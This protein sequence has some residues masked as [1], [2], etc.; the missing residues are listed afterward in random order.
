MKSAVHLFAFI[1]IFALSIQASIIEVPTDYP[2]IQQ[3][4]NASVSGDLVL[5]APGTYVENIDFNGKNILLKSTDGPA[6]TTIDGS[7]PSHPDLASVVS[8]KNGEG[9]DAVLEGFTITGGKGTRFEVTPNLMFECGGGVFCFGASP[10]IK[11]NVIVNNVAA[12]QGGGIYCCESGSVIFDNTI[13]DNTASLVTWSTVKGGGGVYCQNSVCTVSGNVI[14]GNSAG[15]GNYGSGGGGLLGFSSYITASQ[16]IVFGNTASVGGGISSLKSK[17]LLQ[18]NTVTGNSAGLLGGG[19]YCAGN[20]PSTVELNLIED[21]QSNDGGGLFV[22]GPHL[23]SKNVI[24]NNSSPSIGGGIYGLGN[25]LEILSNKISCNQSGRGGGIATYFSSPNIV[26]NMINGNT[27]LNSGGGLF[28][29]SDF[30]STITNNTI[31]GNSA[32]NSGGGISCVDNSNLTV[33]NTILWNNDAP[34]GK[35]IW[36]GD[37]GTSWPSVLDLDYSDV[38]GGKASVF[39][40]PNST[41]IWGSHVLDADPIFVDEAQGDFHLLFTSPCKS[42]GTLDAFNT[43][44]ADFE[45]NERFLGGYVDIG[46]D[47]FHPHL[48]VTGDAVPGGSVEG[49]IIGEPGTTD[50]ILFVGSGLLTPPQATFWGIFHLQMPLFIIQLGTIPSNGLLSVPA[51][52]PLSPPAPYDVPMQALIGLNWESMSQLCILKVR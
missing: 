8:F 4:I 12:V 32:V 33:V 26:N 28:L 49:K 39:V 14:S 5:V 16:N 6:M 17:S 18:D 41:L 19:I 46:A 21:N 24:R 52:L 44:N 25:D 1:F 27:A 45:G 34:S 3:A 36:I 31:T 50:V 13:A 51:T 40:D 29:E 10:T 2:T 37:Y 30:A 7:N 35:E 38:E 11:K 23:V 42:A 47:E 15:L 22:S 9:L 20:Q 48:Y 43:P